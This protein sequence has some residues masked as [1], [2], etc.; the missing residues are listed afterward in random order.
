[1]LFPAAFY[2]AYL[3]A[4]L[5]WLGISLGSLAIGLLHHLTGG[6]WGLVIRRELEAAYSTLPLMAI[7]FLPLL[8]GMEWLYPWAR[9]DVVAH[10]TILQAKAKYLNLN[11]FQTRAVIYFAIWI[12]TGFVL[13]RI[14]AGIDPAEEPRRQRKL[15]LISG[16]CLILWG[17]TITFASIDWAMSLEPHWYSSMY[18][19]LYMAGFA[20][21]GLA[22]AILVVSKLA[23]NSP[24]NELLTADRLHDLGNLLL[25]FTVFW[26]YVSFM[27][28]LIIWSG[29]LPED[30]VWYVHRTAGSWQIVALLLVFLHF[31][32]PFVLL[33]SRDNKRDP[34][35]LVKVAMLLLVMRLIDLVWL[36][37]PAF[38][39]DGIQFHW[40]QIVSPLAIG[41]LWLAWFAW[42]LPARAALPVF[43][44]PSEPNSKVVSHAA[45]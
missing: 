45:R 11:F 19:V 39:P 12:L 40:L 6:A 44:L 2:P 24:W 10:D 25:A 1:M 26:S 15:A 18:G 23:A 5:F 14:S 29:N 7:L 21:S 8:A 9:A 28:Y 37:Q 36:V 42:R 31:I 35:R 43:E 38:A 32:F 34:Q 4:W 16:P 3:V 20:V 13:N 33:L 41:G 22:L 17:L 27:Q 30:A